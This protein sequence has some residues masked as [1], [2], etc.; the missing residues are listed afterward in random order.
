[1]VDVIPRAAAITAVV[2]FLS[3]SIF[4][5]QS[6]DSF[7]ARIVDSRTGT[8][9]SGAVVSVTG[10]SGSVK[11]DA[12][13]RFRM[14]P[15]PTPPFQIVVVMPGGQVARPVLIEAVDSDATIPV[16]A[17]ADESVT[18][19][20]A[21]PSIDASPAAATTMLSR[22]QV[23]RRSPE[24]LL[25][26]LETV[27]GI[28][29]VSEGHAAVPA[30][31]GMARGR[32]LLLVDGARVTSERRAGPSA[33]F[34]DP[35]V[36]EG[37][38]VARGPGSVA[39]GS[40][41]LGGVISVRSKRV[42]PRSGLRASGHM[43]GGVG[44]PEGR[45]SVEVSRGFSKGGVLLEGHARAAGDWSSPEDDTRIVNSGW[46]DG[47]FLMKGNQEVGPGVLSAGWQ[48]DFGRDVERPRNNSTAVRFYYP[49]ENSHR[50]TTSYDVSHAAGFDEIALTGFFGTFEQR[51]DQDRLPT[52]AAAR[53][54]E[55]A[56]LAAKDF[57]V[58]GTA[59]RGVGRARLELGVDVNG[60]YDLEALD[61]IQAYDL[62]GNMI[63]DSTGVSIEGARRTD[64]GAF[65]Q[66]D[67]AVAPLFRASGGV[68]ADSVTTRSTGGFFGDRATSHAAF[69]GFAAGTVGRS[70][71]LSATAQ[72][73][74]GF[75]DPTLSDRYFRGPSGRG[76]ITG[77]PHLAPETSLQL[78]VTGRYTMARTQVV[79]SYYAYRI[80]HL[81]ERY[82]PQTDFFFFRNRG[83]GGIQG[84]EVEARTELGHGYAVELG[85]QI[86]RGEL[87]DDGSGL[88]D[89]SP[90]TL[91][92][93]FRRDFGARAHA[94]IR[95]A[96]MAHDDRPG[97]SEISAPN[98]AIF[99]L[100][101]GYRLSEHLELR[102]VVRNLLDDA[103]YASPDPRWVWA[104]GRSGSLTV[105]LAF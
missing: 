103:Y 47:G 1:L 77:N 40:D 68:R 41:A 14:E 24:H 32:V 86:A 79:L 72:I 87:A 75:R 64:V 91:L 51:T 90:D 63:S 2:A 98:A 30:I 36:L 74:R 58:K 29:Q 55:R 19:I 65:V 104:P 92:A 78:D 43:T 99:D 83:R 18:V 50:F 100:A 56:D 31:R 10:V 48:G 82:T 35:A 66:A 97:P 54:L 20:G 81:I 84:L 8:P 3:A 16:D 37:I 21:A 88:D 27:P 45:G 67:V 101:G 44:V 9:V 25:Q 23:A 42:Q 93:L 15:R 6:A 34:L 71:G 17:I 7:S 12:D 5:S 102:G 57:H 62:A 33:T 70:S 39:Y 28:S 11:T 95:M 26:A 46:R 96:L 94:Q 89:I 61:I 76:F 105:A 85:L 53:T 52:P 80:D 49:Y 13:G 59:R 38:D 60:R 22:L 4:A 69:S 73:S